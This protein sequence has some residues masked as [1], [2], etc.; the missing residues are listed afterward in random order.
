MA[1]IRRHD[2]L[3][4]DKYKELD[5][6]LREKGVSLHLYTDDRHADAVDILEGTS[7]CPPPR[8]QQTHLHLPNRYKDEGTFHMVKRSLSKAIGGGLIGS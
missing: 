4:A 3:A 7:D 1:A 5:I 6:Q 8:F 2:Y